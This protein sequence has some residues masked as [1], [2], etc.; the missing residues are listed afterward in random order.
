MWDFSRQEYWSGLPFPSP[1]GLVTRFKCIAVTL[2]LLEQ[3]LPQNKC[4]KN[5]TNSYDS[6]S[7]IHTLLEEKKNGN[8]YVVGTKG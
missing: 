7:Q 2:K 3:C 8:E 4:L 6:P 1:V 5:N